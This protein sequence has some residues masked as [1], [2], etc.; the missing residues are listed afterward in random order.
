MTRAE[1]ERAYL[2]LYGD[3][4]I[5]QYRCTGCGTPIALS[6]PQT[7]KHFKVEEFYELIP[8]AGCKRTLRHNIVWPWFDFHNH[9]EPIRKDKRFIPDVYP[10]TVD[11][12]TARF[13]ALI[14]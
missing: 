10:G 2:L 14:Q 8:C 12:K 11:T 13:K 5:D 3:A 1:L 4:Y 7:L 9:F 6:A